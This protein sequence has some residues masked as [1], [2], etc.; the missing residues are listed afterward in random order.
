MKHIGA[1]F[2]AR[3]FSI[4]LVDENYHLGVDYGNQLRISASGWP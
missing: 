3:A 1:Y 2:A 4:A